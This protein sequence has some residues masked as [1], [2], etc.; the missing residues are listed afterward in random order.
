MQALS[1]PQCACWHFVSYFPIIYFHL[2]YFHITGICLSVVQLNILHF[3]FSHFH[4]SHL[5]LHYISYW[6]SSVS[7][8]VLFTS[9]HSFSPL[10]TFPHHTQILYFFFTIPVSCPSFFICTFPPIWLNSAV[11]R[12]P[13][14]AVFTLVWPSWSPLVELSTFSDG[15]YSLGSLQRPFWAAWS[16]LKDI[17][18][19]TLTSSAYKS[20]SVFSIVS[21]DCDMGTERHIK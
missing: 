6:A 11:F 1:F 10:S 13:T 4:F 18:L 8:C 15:G 19:S 3:A 20:L 2:I 21:L 5:L 9:K 14:E 7:F 16:K 12:F 17:P